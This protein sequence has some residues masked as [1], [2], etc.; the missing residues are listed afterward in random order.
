M[1]ASEAI[2]LLREQGVVLPAEVALIAAGSPSAVFFNSS[3]EILEASTPRREDLTYEV[4]YDI[5]GRGEVVEVIL[6]RVTNGLSANYTEPYM[7]RRDPETM[8]I[9]DSRPTDKRGLRMSMAILL[10]G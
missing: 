5:P 9:G 10:T 3:A 4:R 1:I 6:H 7:R 8:L 2:A